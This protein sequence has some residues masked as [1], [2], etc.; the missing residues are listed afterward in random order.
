MAYDKLIFELSSADRV[1]YKLPELDVDRSYLDDAIPAQLKKTT[2][3][4]LPEVSEVDNA[5]LRAGRR[6]LSARLLYDE[7]QSEN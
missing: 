5:Q 7:I 1:A 4:V 6:I 2:E 3:T